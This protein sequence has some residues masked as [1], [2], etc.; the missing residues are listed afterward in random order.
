MINQDHELVQCKYQEWYR[1][2]SLGAGAGAGAGAAA[3][4]QREILQNVY[5]KLRMVIEHLIYLFWVH[6]ICVQQ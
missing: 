1:H 3:S 5:T 4:Q 6:K 2:T